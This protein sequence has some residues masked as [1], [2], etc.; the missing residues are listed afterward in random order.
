MVRKLSYTTGLLVLSLIFLAMQAVAAEK[1]VLKTQKDKV[2]YG[3]GVNIG[4][5]F[6]KEGIEINPD[7]LAKGMKDALAGGKLIIGDDELRL[8]LSAFREELTQKQAQLRKVAAEKNMKEGQA[9]LVEN[10]KKDGVVT[11]PSGL[12]YKIIKA[13]EGKKPLDTDTVDCQYHGTFID[14]TEFDSSYRTGK[15]FSFKVS[16]V[17]PGWVEALKLMPVGSR[18]QLF[19]PPQLAYGEQGRGNQIGPNST[20]IF[21]VELIAIK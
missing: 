7:V 10:G 11:L 18:W 9:F 1:I 17:I 16:G 4:K 15:P 21:D 13:A 8:A 3:I 6:Q 20:L 2:S 12:Q 19:I 5:D 14:G